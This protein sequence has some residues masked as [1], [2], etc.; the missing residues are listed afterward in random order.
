MNFSILRKK[1]LAFRN[2]PFDV[3]ADLVQR[4]QIP[5]LLHVKASKHWR[6]KGMLLIAYARIFNNANHVAQILC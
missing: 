2:C 4:G 6:P 3:P 1:L 5:A